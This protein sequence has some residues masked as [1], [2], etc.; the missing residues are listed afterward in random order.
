[1]TYTIEESAEEIVRQLEKLNSR[2]CDLEAAILRLK[3]I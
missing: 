2:L 1:M 3:G